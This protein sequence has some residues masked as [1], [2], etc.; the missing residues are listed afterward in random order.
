MSKEND[1]RGSLAFI[2]GEQ[3]NGLR[4]DEIL[5]LIN[6]EVNTALDDV[7]Q[8]IGGEEE[9]DFDPGDATYGDS[10]HDHNAVVY[11]RN[12]AKGEAQA[13]VANVKG[14]YVRASYE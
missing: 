9:P 11:G 6:K 8:R 14:E 7:S 5:K 10:R 2:I 3:A 4:G 12:S 1:L 13:H